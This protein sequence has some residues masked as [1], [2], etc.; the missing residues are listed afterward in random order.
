MNAL[1]DLYQ[2]IEALKGINTELGFEEQVQEAAA[3][4][5]T[6]L[7]SEYTSSL[8]DGNQNDLPEHGLSIT[9]QYDYPYLSMAKP[10]AASSGR[11]DISVQDTCI[12]LANHYLQLVWKE[13]EKAQ[14]SV[15]EFLHPLSHYM[16][17]PL[18]AIL[19]Y[20]SLL[21]DELESTQ[22]EE[23]LHYIRRIG[24][25]TKL[26]VKM[27]DD[28]LYLSRLNRED[29]EELPVSDIVAE[30][31]KSLEQL[32]S[33]RHVAIHVQEEIPSLLMNR[34]HALTLI[35]QLLSNAYN[36]TE[37]D[38]SIHIGYRDDEFFIKDQGK[39]I[40]PDNLGKVFRIFFTT[41]SKETGCTGAG[42]YIVK[43]ILD[44]YGGSIRMESSVGR[45]TTVYFK[46]KTRV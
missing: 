33:S 14:R 9:V 19:G 15:H 6:F 3:R 32:D 22:D 25:N 38:P 29:V 7:K 37:R 39:G 1:Q 4:V 26:L 16:K 46:T 34:Q 35:G 8:D 27:I 44:M 23:I 36:H 42:L 24:K 40:S 20:S 45:G 31:M 30:S 17:S 5:S 12:L 10:I 43:K 13:T 21:E 11:A 28:L 41:C 18:T 2:F